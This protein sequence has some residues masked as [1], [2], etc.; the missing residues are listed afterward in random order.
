MARLAA[1]GGGSG[2]SLQSRTGA[3]NARMLFSPPGDSVYNRE[4]NNLSPFLE[5]NNLSPF[6]AFF[7]V[8]WEHLDVEGLSD[9]RRGTDESHYP[10]W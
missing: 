8:F 7:A 5:K 6:F 1:S 9:K 2:S 10:V 4:K 3:A